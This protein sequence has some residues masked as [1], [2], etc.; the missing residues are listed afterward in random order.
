MFTGIIESTGKIMSIVQEH[1]NLVLQIESPITPELKIDQSVAHNG[2]CLTITAIDENTHTVCAVKE[3]IDKT[4]ISH[5]KI[6][7]IVNLE[8]C[9]Q[10]NGRLDGHIVQ[11]HVDTTAVC[12]KRTD[13]EQNWLF[14]F[15]ISPSFSHLIIEKGSVSINGTSLTCFNVTRTTFEVTI[16]PYTFEHTSI[17]EV[18]EGTFVNIEFDV[19][20]KYIA[21]MKEVE[22]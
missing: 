22:G 15:E 10:L 20:G 16:I 8:R 2:I 12:I 7:N 19:I 5:W 17:P 6:G 18:F 3:T 14:T 13:L 9:M 4:T 1:Q 21:R 11:G